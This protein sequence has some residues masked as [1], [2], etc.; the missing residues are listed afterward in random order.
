MKRFTN[1]GYKLSSPKLAVE[2]NLV[3]QTKGAS[4]GSK[5]YSLLAA[6]C[7]HGSSS[8]SGHYTAY[9]RSQADPD[10]W[11]HCNDERVSEIKDMDFAS[12][13]ADSYI[14]FYESDSLSSRL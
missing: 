7:H 13:L 14:L 12:N 10:T 2:A 9:C 6:V 1:E 8:R 5:S 4:G 3:I 11:I